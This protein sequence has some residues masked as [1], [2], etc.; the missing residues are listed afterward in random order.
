[1]TSAPA[2]LGVDV[3][4]PVVAVVLAGALVLEPYV[5]TEPVV[6]DVEV[7]VSDDVDVV[8]TR[9]ME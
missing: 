8:V 4:T 2:T 1:V 3:G 7:V 6:D 9:L 5:A